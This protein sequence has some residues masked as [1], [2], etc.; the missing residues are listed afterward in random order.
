MSL[1]P[2]KS[3]DLFFKIFIIP[4]HEHI[5]DP[6]AIFYPYDEIIKYKYMIDRSTIM[7]KNQQE[8]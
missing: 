5:Y 2:L 4:M 1:V 7:D 6:D 8:S 3:V